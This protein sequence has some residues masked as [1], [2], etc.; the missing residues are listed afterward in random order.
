MSLYETLAKL[1]IKVER[2]SLEPHKLVIVGGQ[3]RHTTVI[4]LEGNNKAGLGEDVTYETED[5]L[6]FQK[7]GPQLDLTSPTTLDEF[8]E[9]VGGMDLFPKPPKM[10]VF[11]RY[12]R[13]A[14]ESA[15]LDLALRQN[16]LSLAEAVGREPKAVHF[17]VSQRLGKPSSTKLL[18]ARLEQYPNLRFKLDPTND[19]DDAIIKRLVETKAVQTLDLK[20]FYKGTVVDVETDPALYRKLASAF[21]DAYLEDPDVTDET[22]PILEPHAAR[23][24]WDA[25]LHTAEDILHMPFQPKTINVKPSRFGGIEEL[26]KVYELCGRENIAM[27]SGGQFELDVG[28]GHIQYLASLFHPDTPND[29]SPTAYHV[30]ELAPGLPSTVLEPK[31]DRMGFRW[32]V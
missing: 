7:A 22:R 27:Y 12:R 17:V 21:S 13:W 2:Y 31:L 8:C 25:P 1:P 30:D 16:G 32:L 11:R 6:A 4:R 14:F 18:D 15:A 19:W 3:D 5:Q 24:T 20:G 28:R 9:L 23:I 10:E 26:C 29:A